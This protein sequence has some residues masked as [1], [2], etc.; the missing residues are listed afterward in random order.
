MQ[1]SATVHPASTSPFGLIGRYC[2][3]LLVCA[4]FLG[5]PHSALAGQKPVM[6]VAVNHFAPWKILHPDGQVTG[7]D[8]DFL[9]E[10]ADRMGIDLE[11]QGMPFNRGLAKMEAG[12]ADLMTGLLKRPDREAYMLFISPPYKTSSNKAFYTLAGKENSIRSYEDLQTL[13]IG[14]HTRKAKYFPR[15]DNDD[16]IKKFY[17]GAE[18]EKNI[19]R[20]FELLDMKRVDAFIHTESVIDYYLN[21]NGLTDKYK[22]APYVYST[23]IDV[24]M[25]ISKKSKFASYHDAFNKQIAA[26]LREGVL[27]KIKRDYLQTPK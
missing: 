1:P 8:I 18:G 2:A 4:L 11:F 19:Q 3:C 21:A 14:Y 16:S 6:I 25:A 15:F 7:I 9:R 13:T 27:E 26:L 5:V 17:T 20:L 12:D 24:Y 22:K 10:A 23:P